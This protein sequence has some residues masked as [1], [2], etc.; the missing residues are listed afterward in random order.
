MTAR[1]R[2]WALGAHV[3][4]V[5]S[6]VIAG[7]LGATVGRGQGSRRMRSTIVYPP[8][9]IA[10]R[11]DHSLNAHRQL[12]CERC[13]TEA[14]GS[15]RAADR[16]IP[17]ERT[18]APCHDADIR[19]GEQ[20]ACQTCHV[21]AAG[22]QGRD[23]SADGAAGDLGTPL[24]MASHFPTARLRFS[25][26]RHARAGVSCRACH[27]EVP[28]RGVATRR[29]L[30]SME[31]C[32][33]CHEAQRVSTEC[34]TCHLTT[35]DG[36]LRTAYPEGTLNPPPSTGMYHDRDF[37]V[38]HRWVAADRGNDCATC[39]T[40][41]QC[42]ACHDGR[43]R[44]DS[45]HPGDFLTTHP[46]LARRNEARCATCHNV[47]SF[48]NECH[49]RL[50][51]SPASAPRV[52][53]RMRYHPP[54]TTWVEGPSLHGREARRSMATCASCHS[55]RDCIECHGASGI[56]E[57]VSPHPPGF[58]GRCDRLLQRNSRACVLCHGGNAAALRARCG[59]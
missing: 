10:L 39:H 28:T 49:S 32:V 41:R 43:V 57:G 50:G 15:R 3:A 14:L 52:A 33:S 13:H 45:V 44:P 1:D 37:L 2:R 9:R 42:V 56:G 36:R 4:V 21:G 34:R 48:C 24:I 5:L 17:S 46:Q 22:E 18:C 29:D 7:L 53:S 51:L 11:M 20:G 58:A 27:S 23:G 8:Q 6:L 59:G 55:E 38:R 47:A 54:A 30:P 35:A 31:R 19:G 16:L 12:Q 26:Q 25:H 40:N